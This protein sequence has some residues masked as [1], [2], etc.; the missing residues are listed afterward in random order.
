MPGYEIVV[1]QQRAIVDEFRLEACVQV[2]AKGESDTRMCRGRARKGD[3]QVSLVCVTADNQR[4]ALLK[5][6]L[7]AWCRPND[8]Y[9]PEGMLVCPCSRP[10][11]VNEVQHLTA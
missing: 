6:G 3:R 2:G 5:G 1:H 9:F 8:P 11:R 7:I 4:K 10:Y